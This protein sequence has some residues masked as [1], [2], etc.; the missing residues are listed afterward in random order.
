V[1]TVRYLVADVDAAVAF[2]AALGFV[3]AERW[4]PPFAVMTHGDLTLWVSGPGT[5]AARTLPDGSEPRPG[6]WN[7]LVLE[8]PDLDAA[9]SGLKSKGG[10]FRSDPI[11]GPGGRQVLCE[12]PSGNPVELFQP[13]SEAT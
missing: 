6:G 4:G 2:Y 5:S 13:R 7:R 10:R 12:D 11:S 3:L 1:A 8:V 9:V